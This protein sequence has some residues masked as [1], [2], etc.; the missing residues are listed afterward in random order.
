MTT[1]LLR[2]PALSVLLALVACQSTPPAASGAFAC[3]TFASGTFASGRASL[4]AP[5]ATCRSEP[6]DGTTHDRM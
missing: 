5:H 6:L 4:I 1:S 3:G 2:F